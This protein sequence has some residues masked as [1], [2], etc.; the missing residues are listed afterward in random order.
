[1]VIP[2]KRSVLHEK[3][4]NTNMEIFKTKMAKIIHTK[5]TYYYIPEESFLPNYP[6]SS[7]QYL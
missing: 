3:K 2:Y 1:M 5:Q 7:H 4:G 6:L